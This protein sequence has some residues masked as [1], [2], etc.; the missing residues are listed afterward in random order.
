MRFDTINISRLEVVILIA[1]ALSSCTVE[2]SYE[3]LE[4]GIKKYDKG[5]Y[6]KAI[7]LFTKS[8]EL[9]SLNLEAYNYRG[10]S[11][12]KTFDIDGAISDY[13][14]IISLDSTYH[15][16]LNNRGVAYIEVGLF[17]KA[18]EDF[19]EAIVINPDQ[20]DIYV[21]RSVAKSKSGEIGRAS[22]RERV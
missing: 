13:S 16:A 7:V 17:A 10:L 11:K 4:N 5:L 1:L 21:S 3:Y 18:V 15:K 19:N 2:S 14:T 6:D 9:D 8:I 12:E 22:C 20:A